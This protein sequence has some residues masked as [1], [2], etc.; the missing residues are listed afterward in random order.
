MGTEQAPQQAALGD[1]ALLRSA[2]YGHGV[3]PYPTG[4][5]ASTVP[6]AGPRLRNVAS[7]ALVAA[8]LAAVATAVTA[9]AVTGQL[10][11]QSLLDPGAVVR[12]GLPV[13]RV[14]QDGAAVLTVGLLL[15]AAVILPDEG[16]DRWALRG[17]R[18]RVVQWAVP[19]ACVWAAAVAVMLVLT[20]SDVAGMRL[21]SPGFGQQVLFFAREVELGRTMGATL[22]LVLV[23]AQLAV[24]A[25]RLGTAGWAALTALVALLPVALGGHAAGSNDHANAVNGL[26]AHLVSVTVWTGGVAALLVLVAG[27]GTTVPGLER[28]DRTAARFSGLA[29]WCFVGVA[30]SG[31]DTA[32]VRLGGIDELTSPYGVLLM[33]KTAALVLLGV[34]GWVHRRRTLPALVLNPR[35]RSTFTRLLAAEFLVMGVAVGLAVALARSAPMGAHTVG[36][37]PGAEFLA[38]TGFQRPPPISAATILTQ[39]HIDWL[40]LTI[41]VVLAGGYLAWVLR[42]RRSGDLWPGWRAGCWT[43]G[44]LLLVWLTSG[45]PSVYGMSSFSGHMLMHMLL[46]LGAPPLLAL[47][48]PV[49]LALRALPVRPDASAGPREWLVAVVDSRVIQT[50]RRPPVAGVL[51]GASLVVFYRTGLFPLSM[52]THTGHMLMLACFTVVGY[53]FAD[54]VIGADHE[55]EGVPHRTRLLVLLGTSAVIVTFGVILMTTDSLLA[56]EWWQRLGYTDTV[57]LR[58]DQRAGAAVACAAGAL[59]LLLLLVTATSTRTPAG[60]TRAIAGAAASPR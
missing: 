50:L 45:G 6:E 33:A 16:Q 42:L 49:T 27:F 5:S 25:T 54:S 38:L 43:A 60:P 8:P 9:L 3:R 47:G 17:A 18:E 7:S 44:C 20:C 39:W 10:A 4:L 1:L 48:A 52:A 30:L 22:V 56:A 53:L 11:E 34:A 41:G 21:G 57:A 2:G 59:P 29:L 19:A 26:A 58:D 24:L 35:D 28:L 36:A 14:V 23:C 13:T 31:L 12:Y 15:V 40:L 37:G 32:W 51:L 55:T 46:M